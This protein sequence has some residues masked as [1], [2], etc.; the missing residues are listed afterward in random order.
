VIAESL[1]MKWQQNRQSPSKISTGREGWG[2][3][4][5]MALVRTDKRRTQTMGQ[6]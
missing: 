3:V 5:F 2:C 6:A 1:R 4:G